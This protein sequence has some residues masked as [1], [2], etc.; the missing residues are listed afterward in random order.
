MMVTSVDLLDE[1]LKILIENG[2][3]VRAEYLGDSNGGLCRL[4]NSHQL[5]LNVSQSAKEHLP[6][7]LQ[8]LLELGLDDFSHSQ[9]LASALAS[10]KSGKPY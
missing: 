10:W 1:S 6:I 9:P 3:H 8:A 7:A 4:G 2:V 5:I